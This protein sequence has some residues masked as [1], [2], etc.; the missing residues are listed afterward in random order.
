MMATLPTIAIPPPTA[1]PIIAPVERTLLCSVLLF[2]VLL[3][4]VLFCA[5][6]C[7]VDGLVASE[8]LEGD[9]RG[10]IV[11]ARKVVSGI[12]VST[13]ENQRSVGEFGAM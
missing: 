12:F 1:I 9:E 4:A 7:D 11:A 13:Q 10:V 2:S 5:V 6:L 8:W 3:C